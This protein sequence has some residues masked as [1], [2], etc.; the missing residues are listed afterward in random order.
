MKVLK[1]KYGRK[2]LIH[3]QPEPTQVRQNNTQ[4]VGNILKRIIEEKYFD[5]IFQHNMW[6]VSNLIHTQI[7]HNQQDNLQT[8]KTQIYSTTENKGGIKQ[9]FEE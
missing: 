1:I 3:I 4:I 9:V 5:D 6:I 2:K 7:L 8:E